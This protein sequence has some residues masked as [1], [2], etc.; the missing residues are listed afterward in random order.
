MKKSLFFI[1]AIFLSFYCQKLSAQQ[2]KPKVALVLSGGGAKGIAHIP[3]LQTLDSLGIVPDIIIGTSM[4]GVVG[5]FY[6]VG[7]SGD[8]ISHIAHTANWSELLGGD[9]S[10]DDVSMEEKSE[11]KR[12]LVDF[13]IIEGKPKVNS[14]LLKDQKL[15]EFITS[16]TY[17]VFAV[18]DFDELSIPY[19][20]MT[21]DIVNGREVL[22]EGG[23]LSLAMR[24]TMSIPAVFQPIP[25][26]NTLLVD[27][28]VM[29]NFPVD[30][31]QQMGYDF[32]IG[33]D[34]GGGLQEKEKLNSITAQLFQAAMLTS[35]LKNPSNR[36]SCDILVDHM[37]FLTH[38]TG[39]FTKAAEI[40]EEGKIGTN[41]QLPALAE[42]AAKLKNYKQR[43]HKLP[44]VK[45]EF[46]LDS[47]FYHDISE[48]NLD[49]VKARANLQTGKKYSSHE[50]INGIDKAMGTNLFNQITYDGG[51]IDGK[52]ELHLTGHE[53]SM[54]I[55]KGSLHYDTYR[56][57]GLMVNYT[58]RNLIGKSSRILVTV[59]IAEQPRFRLQYQKQFGPEKTWWWR[60]EALA[61]FLEQKFYYKGA[62]AEAFKSNYFQ[63]DNQINKNLNSL[64]SYAGIGLSYEYSGMKPKN[65]TEL[66]ENIIE[67]YLFSNL[68][69][70]AHYLFSKMDK[71]Y[72]PSKGTFFRLGVA[73]SL[74]HDVDV[75]YSD[76]DTEDVNGSTNGFT[77]A[78]LDFERRWAFSDK[79]S[80]ILGANAAFIFQDK[81]KSDDNWFN[82]YGYAAMYSMGGTVTA[83]RKGSYVFPGLHEDELF[84]N[85]MMRLNLAVQI[86]PFSK[87]Y[88]SP[89]VNMATVGFRGFNE[90]IENAFSPV[91]DWSDGF[92]T[93]SVFSAGINVGYHSFLG[94]LNFDI[95]YVNDVNKVRVFFSIGILFNRSN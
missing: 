60:S 38:S 31:A 88:F 55:I 20:A 69:I 59:D 84:V 9:I 40:Y 62:V 21:T 73:R 3:L 92:E 87:F 25:Y 36:E 28:G 57:V 22:L 83:P 89:H 42:L 56:G 7:Y 67:N 39:D 24:A 8:S 95:S 76:M 58:G 68:E 41:L 70:D 16:Y 2:E 77:K 66:N 30:V 74:I 81:L 75:N 54:S 80:G 11:F 63:F 44:D 18:N 49:L 50:I 64:H 10:L 53:R 34:V 65:T 19:R 86:N 17:P 12:H 23:S 51:I 91:G 13:D 48:A 29:N 26:D 78:M 27:G 71:V 79:V 72:F 5:G 52:K 93:S 46:V 4:G 47:I 94:P 33:S 14:G 1:L 6:A 82:D 35:N 15:R 45:D 37:P 61:E 43:E 85:Q 32:I 90:Y